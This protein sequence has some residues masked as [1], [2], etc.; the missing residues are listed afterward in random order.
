MRTEFSQFLR[1]QYTP[2]PDEEIWE[3]AARHIDFSLSP[4]YDTPVHAQFDPN[5][6]PYMKQPLEWLKDYTTRELWIRKCSRA[7]A[8]EYLLAWLRWKVVHRA[9]PTYY[10]T[11][12]QLTTERFMES[13]IKRGFAACPE[14]NK[15]YKLARVTEHDIR[16]RG[17]DF[18]VSWPNAKG[19]FKQDG[20]AA[21]IADEFPTWKAFAAD[22][23]RKR[24]GT[25]AFHKLVGL[26]SPDPVGKHPD[27]D[28]VILEYDATDRCQWMMRDPGS[29]NPFAFEFGG[30][31]DG[32]GL[33]WPEDCRDA[34]TGEW[35]L[36]RV[37]REAYYLTP[38]GTILTNDQRT[39]LV[40]EAE[41][42]RLDGDC[43]FGWVAQNSGAPS[44][45][46]G[47]WIVGPMVP[48][49]DG[50]FGTLAYRFLEAKRRG[51]A[52]LR[53]YFLENWADTGSMPNSN[54]AGDNSLR[55]RELDYGR[56]SKFYEAKD[57]EG[58]L[59]IP[60]SEDAIRGL[61]MTVD[62]QKYHLWWVTRWWTVQDGQ[63]RSGLEEWGNIAS[64]GDL[65][66]IIESVQPNAV[67]IDIG[68]TERFGETADFC[69]ATGA[70]ALKGE[71]NMKGDLYLRDDMNPTE[72]RKATSRTS[73]R[74][75]ML[76]WNTDVF[77]SK[78]LAA[79]RGETPWGWYIPKMAG[80][81]YIRQVMSTHKIDGEW[82]TKKGYPQD[83]MFDCEVMQLALARFDNLI[84]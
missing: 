7:G 27:G 81:E 16:F 62:V 75:T 59:V 79:L 54:T 69:A 51:M 1:A 40:L 78:F 67:G 30:A 19:A 52:A 47:I 18:R 65:V 56:G 50:D 11:A 63:T 41:H 72:G 26:G 23:L 73:A 21:I 76:T 15:E 35:D 31:K 32:Y 9:E 55:A 39:H 46:H 38:D 68:Y 24:A 29:G 33:K 8:T 44:H 58:E 70:F 83:H 36:E 45:I 53:S 71:D 2:A 74:Y 17:M 66:G 84:Q 77:R 43:R 12:D 42:L 13:R 57:S 5:Y 10:L 6:A 28:P 60:A 25:Y 48:F 37:R 49:G 61:M 82:C 34:E 3:W 80:R 4:N 22:M 64:F 20:W 14:A